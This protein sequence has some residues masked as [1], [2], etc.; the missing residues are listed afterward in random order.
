[1]S[2]DRQHTTL[3]DLSQRLDT[4]ETLADQG[5]WSSMQDAHETFARL[6]QQHF[7]ALPGLDS[8]SGQWLKAAAIRLERLSLKAAGARLKI[9]SELQQMNQFQRAE[10][11]YQQNR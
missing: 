7:D 5:E 9:G 1:M 11:A 4:L 6:L 2:Q 8:A 10:K 3:S